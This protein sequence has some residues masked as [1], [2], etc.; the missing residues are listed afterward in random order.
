ML[1]LHNKDQYFRLSQLRVAVMKNEKLIAEA[2]DSARTQR[3]EMFTLGSCYQATA[4]EDR[5]LHVF[6]C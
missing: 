2:Q 1:G 4:I 3:R 6:C 5:I